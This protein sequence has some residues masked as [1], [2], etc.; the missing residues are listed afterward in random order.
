MCHYVACA[1]EILIILPSLSEDLLLSVLSCNFCQVFSPRA[2]CKFMTLK[3]EKLYNVTDPSVH[4]ESIE[5]AWQ[6]PFQAS[7]G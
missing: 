5:R 2:T 6:L 3:A 4:T 7:S 1:G